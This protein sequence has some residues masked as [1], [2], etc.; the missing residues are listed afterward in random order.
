MA[1]VLHDHDRETASRMESEVPDR[2]SPFTMLG[3]KLLLSLNFDFVLNSA[4]F[5]IFY[6][7]LVLV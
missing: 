5:F 3:T 7:F 2:S 1:D 4:L 6:L